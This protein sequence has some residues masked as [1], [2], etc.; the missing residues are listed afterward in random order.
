MPDYRLIQHAVSRNTVKACKTLLLGAENGEII[1]L[2]SVAV[3]KQRR[4]VT[5]VSQVLP[6]E[7][8]PCARHGAI[9]GR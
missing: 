6:Q 4:Y 2:S 1:G 5:N 7:P 8:Y 9:A 3:L